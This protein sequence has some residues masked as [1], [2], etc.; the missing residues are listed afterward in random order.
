MSTCCE[1]GVT[2]VLRHSTILV[3]IIIVMLVAPAYAD[4]IQVIGE[5]VAVVDIATGVFTFN[6]PVT[7]TDG[8]T[9]MKGTQLVYKSK[10]EIVQFIGEVTIEQDGTSMVGQDLVYD[11]SKGEGVI[12]DALVSATPAGAIS[13]VYVAGEQ[14]TACR[15]RAVIDDCFMTTCDPQHPGY[16]LASRRIEIVPGE[17]LVLHNVRFVE[18]GITLFYWPR[19]T[20]S[21]KRADPDYASE[22]VVLPRIGYSVSEGWYVKSSYGYRGPGDQRGRL[23]IDYMQLLGWGF[24]VD[25]TLR[26]GSSGTDKLQ[27]YIQ[28]NTNTG[29]NDLQL[30]LEG[31]RVLPGNVRLSAG[32][33]L[34]TTYDEGEELWRHDHLTLSHER[35][36]GSS[37]LRY[38]DKRV[39]GAQQGHDISGSLSHSQN[40]DDGWHMRFTGTLHKRDMPTMTDRNLVGFMA[41]VG[42]RMPNWGFDLVAE[43][44][45]NPELAKEFPTEITWHRAQRLPELRAYVDKISLAGYETPFAVDMA[46]GYLRED[47]STLSG[48][49]RTSTHRTH[50]AVK[51]KPLQLSLGSLGQLQW[52]GSAT[53]R[54]YGTGEE[55]WVAAAQGEYRLPLTRRLSL[56]GDYRYE[57]AL[58]DVSPFSFDRVNDQE[59]LQGRLE[60][61]S[62]NLGWSL[63]GRY[64][65]LRS[66][67]IDAVAGLRLQPVSA[68]RLQAQAAYSLVD[69]DWLYTIGTAEYVPHER[70]SLKLGA[71][72]NMQLRR[73]DRI[74]AAFIWDLDTWKLSYT[75]I[76]DGINGRFDRGDFT[77]TRDLGCRAIDLRYNQ[78]RQEIWLEYRITA[79][80][81][82]SVKVGATEK[83]LMF[84]ARGWEEVLATE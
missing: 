14:V 39:T 31:E 33:S 75:G 41:N 13:P 53:R 5:E 50:S 10:E 11:A 24:G 84:D 81:D 65:L 44:R 21:L 71:K 67:P 69:A 60:Y 23:L 78:S 17:R 62:S 70:L 49:Q 48:T 55:Q 68:L 35:D 58:G 25:H 4:S 2:A 42:R 28:P 40:T 82:A 51:V 73:S 8:A 46:W 3:L 32:S 38:S 66:E 37:A 29:H 64:D 36:K 56:S 54:A 7:V 9:T 20:F 52:S 76:Y 47:R 74:D 18:S 83:H 61:Q 80:P 19:V 22:E 15:Q 59:K 79:F 27:V 43:E 34:S 6:G 45:F 26:S 57:Q 1:G 30:S 16:Y 63:G 12:K 72:Y 77:I